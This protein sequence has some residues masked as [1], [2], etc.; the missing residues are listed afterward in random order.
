MNEIFETLQ[1]FWALIIAIGGGVVTF[2]QWKSTRRKS[3]TMLYDE[4][5]KLKQKVI[6]QVSREVEQ[7]SELAEKSR[8]IEEFKIH[9]PDC[10]SSFIEKFDSK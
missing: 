2:F 7:A 10:Y 3:T 9:C 5:E 4:L 8:I 6:L 1:Q